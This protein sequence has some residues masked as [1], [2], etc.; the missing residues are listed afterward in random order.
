MYE[1]ERVWMGE[2]FE[3]ARRAGD[4]GDVPVGAVVI[5]PSGEVVGRGYNT[6]E[7]DADPAGHAE[8]NAMREAAGVLGGWNL[9]GCTLVVSLEPCTMCA[10]AIVNARVSRVVFGAWDEKAGAAGSVRDVLRDARLGA[11]IEV[12]GGL[13]QET[14]ARQLGEWF[15]RLR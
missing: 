15:E 12:I 8:I 9:S 4:A 11:P 7:R 10:G 1:I 2:A 5:S 14:A 3:L 6:R 13:E